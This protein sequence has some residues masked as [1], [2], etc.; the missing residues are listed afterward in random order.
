MSSIVALVDWTQVCDRSSE[1]ESLL[2][3]RPERCCDGRWVRALGPCTLGLGLRATTR[4]QQRL[5][6]PIHR[7]ELAK[8]LVV[9]DA[10]IDNFEDLTRDLG[11]DS[12]VSDAALIA[13]AYARWDLDAAHRLDGDFAFVVWDQRRSRL[14]AARDRFGVRTMSYRADGRSL[15]IATEVGQVLADPETPR[16]LD[17][18]AML[19]HLTWQYQYHRLTFFQ[20]IS[21]LEPGH[22]LVG[23]RDAVSPYRYWHPS[24]YARPV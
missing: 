18:L 19:D 10:R 5:A 14:Y 21:R 7:D 4:R 9:C 24:A 22:Y 13:A 23:T 1:V 11:L 2:L 20:A 8:T 17:D 12:G 16:Q 3:I 15:L 6:E